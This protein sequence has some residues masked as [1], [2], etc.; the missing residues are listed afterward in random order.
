MN[1]DR[2]TKQISKSISEGEWKQ[3]RT[4]LN[5]TIFKETIKKEIAMYIVWEIEEYVNSFQYIVDAKLYKTDQNNVLQKC[6]SK[7]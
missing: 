7:G 5:W 2:L 4:G 6:I 3:G 1:G